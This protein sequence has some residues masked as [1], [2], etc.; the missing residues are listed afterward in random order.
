MDTPIHKNFKGQLDDEI[1]ICY[2][3]RH[4]ATLIPTFFGI[5]FIPVVLVLMVLYLPFFDAGNWFSATAVVLFFIGLHIFIQRQFLKVFYFYLSTVILTN[6]RVVEV[7]KSVFLK[8]SKIAI[9][10][11]NV[12]DIEKNQS[13]FLQTIF[14][15]GSLVIYLSGSPMPNIIKMVPR[16]E[17]QYKKINEVKAGVTKVTGMGP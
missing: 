3:R 11:I 2:F 1:V 17:Y 12:Q 6:Y 15:Y 8:D 10:L 9:E 14:N 16:P 5:L 4:W 7:D 13:G